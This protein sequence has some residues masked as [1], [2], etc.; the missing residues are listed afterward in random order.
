LISDVY[1]KQTKHTPS[2]DAV[3]MLM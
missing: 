3:K 1:Q 2:R